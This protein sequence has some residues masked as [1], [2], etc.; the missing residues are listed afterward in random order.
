RSCTQDDALDREATENWS[1]TADWKGLE[2]LRVEQGG[3]DDTEGVVEFA[4]HYTADGRKEEHHETA[5]FIKQEGTW[6]YDYGE[7]KTATVV[8]GA[9]KVGRNEPCPCGSG[10]KFK[11]CHGKLN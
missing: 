3:P 11:Q 6:L 1:R 5:R 4:A 2:I 9:P 10:K 8:R 7:V